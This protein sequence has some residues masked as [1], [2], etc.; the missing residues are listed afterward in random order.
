M[1]TTVLGDLLRRAG[2]LDPNLIDDVII[3]CTFPE[4]TQGLNLDVFLSC[5]WDGLTGFPV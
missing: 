2:N 4:A 3:G 5:R 1:A